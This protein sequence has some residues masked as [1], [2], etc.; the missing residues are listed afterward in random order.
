MDNC[1][2]GKVARGKDAGFSSASLCRFST[3]KVY[4]CDLSASKNIAARYFIRVLLKSIPAKE[5]LLA[6]AKVPGLS[7]RT[8]CVLATLIRFTAVLGTLKAA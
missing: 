4:N 2:P 7:R 6:Q 8:S 3:G 5:R 1:L